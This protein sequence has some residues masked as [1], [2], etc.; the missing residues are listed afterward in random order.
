MPLCGSEI[1]I[2]LGDLNSASGNQI[3]QGIYGETGNLTLIGDSR[4]IPLAFGDHQREQLARHS[5]CA[6]VD[7]ASSRQTHVLSQYPDRG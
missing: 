4:R 1:A 5:D 6:A 2:D 7:Q 3:P